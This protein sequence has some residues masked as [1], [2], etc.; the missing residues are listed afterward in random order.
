MKN[1]FWKFKKWQDGVCHTASSE[2]QAMQVHSIQ[3]KIDNLEKY[4][5]FENPRNGSMGYVNTASNI[6][7][8][9]GNAR[10]FNIIQKQ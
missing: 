7:Q 1:L 2:Q 6:Q 4:F 9:A 5:F 8:A 10:Q 3:Y